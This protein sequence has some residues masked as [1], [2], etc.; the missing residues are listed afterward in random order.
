[1]ATTCWQYGHPGRW[2]GKGGERPASRPIASRQGNFCPV[3]GRPDEPER[4][5]GQGLLR[6]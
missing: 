6:F 4:V 2:I 3:N 5:A 1:M